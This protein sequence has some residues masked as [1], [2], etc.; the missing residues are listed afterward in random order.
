MEEPEHSAPQ[1]GFLLRL[2][3][4]PIW[5]VGL[6]VDAAGYVAQAAALGVGKLVVVQP[7]LVSSVIFAL[8]LGVWLTHQRV[9]RREIGGAWRWSPV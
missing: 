1:A 2:L 6:I 3:Q 4:R 7:L 5:L 9:G 8:P